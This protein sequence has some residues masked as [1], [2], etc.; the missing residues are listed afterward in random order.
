ME[1]RSR[2]QKLNSGFSLIELVVAVSIFA[3]V[4]TVIALFFNS[5]IVSQRR[6]VA[7]QN[8]Q[9][10]VRYLIEF[11]AR[12]IRMGSDFDVGTGATNLTLPQNINI[13]S[14]INFLGSDTLKFVNY[15]GESVTY[16]WDRN[17]YSSFYHLILRNGQPI[18]SGDIEI[19]DFAFFITTDLPHPRITVVVKAKMRGANKPEEAIPITVQTTIS[20]RSL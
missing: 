7:S 6:I 14:R 13:F 16:S 9:D 12:E 4:I 18:I 3:I 20:P 17:I 2:K 19:E 8:L 11:M 15:K 1:N 5:S 10:N